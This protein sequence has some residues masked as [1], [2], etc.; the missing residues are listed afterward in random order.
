MRLELHGA[1]LKAGET[2]SWLL[3]LDEDAIK[4]MPKGTQAAIAHVLKTIVTPEALTESAKQSVRSVFNADVK[5]GVITGLCQLVSLRKYMGENETA[6]KGDKAEAANKLNASIGALVGTTI[7][8]IGG[9]MAPTRFGRAPMFAKGASWARATPLTRG[10]FIGF[11]GRGVGAVAG[12]VMAFYDFAHA[13]DE[14]NQNNFG[15]AALYSGSAIL[16]AVVTVLLLAGTTGPF[17]ILAI[18]A[19]V[20]IAVLIEFFKD[21]KLQEWLKRTLWG[22]KTDYTSWEMESADL[23]S[24][25][26]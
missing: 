23:A 5:L 15:M 8:M 25:L 7:E 24:A 3:L 19:L 4:G 9:A 18:A 13:R 10:R 22:K 17:A 20:L 11:L 6:M 21:N 16:G 1:N 2:R 14:F 12:M 26:K